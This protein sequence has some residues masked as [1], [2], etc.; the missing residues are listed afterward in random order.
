MRLNLP[1]YNCIHFEILGE[2]TVSKDADVEIQAFMEQTETRDLDEEGT[3]VAIYGSKSKIGGVTHG[4]H[5]S[6]YRSADEDDVPSFELRIVDERASDELPRPPATLRPVSYLVDASARLFGPVKAYCFAI[7][8]YNESMYQSKVRFPLP[9]IIQGSE[10]G[11]THV[12]EAQFS[13]RVNGDVEYRVSVSEGSSS[14]THLVNFET[15]V[16]L[17]RKSMSQLLDK[18]RSFS[19]QLVV[20]TGDK[21]DV[22]S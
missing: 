8:E 13:R 14:I 15:T 2:F 20:P 3:R 18:A 1:R 21:S 7:F 9:L 19:G 17:D 22:H 6:L 11:V 16:Q 4:V 10:S 12:E 5:G